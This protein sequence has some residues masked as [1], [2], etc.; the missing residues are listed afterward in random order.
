MSYIIKETSELK[1]MQSPE[2]SYIFNKV[3]GLSAVWGKTEE[4][5]PDWCPYGPLI[6]DIEI[7]T[8]CKGPGGKL[9]SFCYKSNTP[10]NGDNMSFETFKKVFDK[11][12]DTLQQIA[13]GVDAQCEMNHDT[14]G[15]MAYCRVNGVIPNVTV[16]DI[17]DTTADRLV[18]LCGAV[19]VS[20]YEDKDICYD[21]IKKLTDRGL[22]QV[23]MHLMI[24]QETF[25]MAMETIEDIKND[26]RLSGLNAIVFL[27]L[28]QKGRGTKFHKLTDQNFKRIVD[29]CFL[30]EISFGFDSCSAVKFLKSVEGRPNYEELYM[31]SE[32]CESARFSAY[33]NV[34]GDYYPCSF[35]EGQGYEWER[36][37][38]VVDCDDFMDIWKC[39]SNKI[40]RMNS[41][42]TI[43]SGKSCSEFD[44]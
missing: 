44:V 42:D 16:A 27:S 24:S 3:T 4:E 30:K 5:D 12:P 29:T 2:V 33:I 6:A 15:I 22:K 13:F 38:S 37:I 41:L 43:K 25:D 21:S 31:V 17:S 11:L 36:G 40:F 7:T 18:E 28:K 10:N 26:P 23:N 20:R 1:V 35:C 39:D 34:H 32:P 14:F 9:C 8:M 19:A